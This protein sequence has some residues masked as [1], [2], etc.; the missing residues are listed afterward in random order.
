MPP[1]ADHGCDEAI[2]IAAGDCCIAANEAI[3]QKRKSAHAEI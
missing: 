3:G 1:A 2:P